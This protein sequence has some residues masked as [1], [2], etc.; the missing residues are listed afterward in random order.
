MASLAEIA[1]KERRARQLMKEQGLSALVL[2]TQVNFAWATGGGDSH[3]AISSEGGSASVVITPEARYIVCDNIEAGRIIEEEAAGLGFQLESYNWWDNRR[4]EIIERLAGGGKIGSDAAFPGAQI[5]ESS[6]APYRVSLTMEEVDRY[7]WIGANTA[8]CM[9]EACRQIKP[10]MAEH[11]IAALLDQKIIARGMIPNVTLIATDERISKYRHPIP[12]DKKLEKYA[13]LVICARK[14]GLICST[15]RLAHF[16]TLS[17]ELRR[18]HNAVVEVDAAFIANTKVGADVASV[19]NAAKAAYAKTGFGEEW[20]LH[21]QG[22][23]TGYLGRDYRAS[24]ATK[25]TVKM[26]QAFAWNPSITGTKSEDTIIALDGKTEVISMAK[27]W[28]YI[29]V[30]VN[31]GIIRRADILEL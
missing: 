27:D 24:S 17:D 22:G 2:S 14:W 15:T 8:E 21:H 29:D 10:G 23:P 18:K 12:S 3:V 7:R 11:E 4:Q 6:L 5:I 30:N 19:F 1:E 28:P 25:D 20:Q 31:G 26:N 9:S 16:G 13:M